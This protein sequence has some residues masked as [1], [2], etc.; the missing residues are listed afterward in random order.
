MCVHVCVCEDGRCVYMCVC[1]DGSVCTCVLTLIAFSSPPKTFSSVTDCL[2]YF[3]T[4]GLVEL[5]NT[6]VDE[7]SYQL[8]RVT[9][10]NPIV[11]YTM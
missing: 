8:P 5:P 2:A 10:I 1:E 9:P 7:D 4:H 3:S 11:S 6:N